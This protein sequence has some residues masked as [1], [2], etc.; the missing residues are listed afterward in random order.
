MDKVSIVRGDEFALSEERSVGRLLYVPG[1]SDV[2]MIDNDWSK[3]KFH[4][5]LFRIIA[6]HHCVTAG[7]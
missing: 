6:L 3:L 5:N 1:L 7:I 2:V 4:I